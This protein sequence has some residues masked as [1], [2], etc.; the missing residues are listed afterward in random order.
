M[1]IEPTATEIRTFL[2]GYGITTAVLGDTW[3]EENRDGLVIPQVECI[4]GYPITAVTPV[5]EILSGT[6]KDILMLSSRPVISVT[7]IEY[8]MGGDDEFPLNISNLQLL[9]E[10]GIIKAKSNMLNY[11]RTFVFMKGEKNIKVTYTVGWTSLP[12][13]LKLAIKMLCAEQILGFVGARTGGGSISTQGH[14]RN[15]G[16]RGKYQDIRND[17]KRQAGCIIGKYT[18]G[19]VG[20]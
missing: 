12:A 11:P 15:Y 8:V 6:G 18:T 19:I 3:I 7:K 20:R 16:N 5:V 14:S 4:I 9:S 2:E 10:E 1:A 13:N 17:L